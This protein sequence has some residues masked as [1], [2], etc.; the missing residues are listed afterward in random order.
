LGLVAELQEATTPNTQIFAS[1]A[2]A[3]LRPFEFAR[4]QFALPYMLWLDLKVKKGV[5]P[6][7]CV[8]NL[9]ARNSGKG[10]KQFVRMFELFRTFRW[11]Q[12]FP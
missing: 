8:H 11:L 4:Q 7:S 1:D 3:S 6:C 5:F 10:S 12:I 9:P 2:L